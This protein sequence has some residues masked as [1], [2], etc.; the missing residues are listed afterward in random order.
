MTLEVRVI[1]PDKT[2]WNGPAQEVI[3]PSTTGQLG[4]LTDH[5]PLLSALDVGVMR[6]RA[7][8]D[9]SA[10]ALMG[11]FAE[12]ED[13]TVTILVNGAETAENID[14]DKAKA[15]YEAAKTT[16]AGIAEGDRQGKIQAEQAYKRSRS[17]FQAVGGMVD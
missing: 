16:L 17:L 15:D 8:K 1:A 6:V 14:R 2:V 4:I 5:A 12:V 10:I 9:W 13:N 7:E 11:G 3:L